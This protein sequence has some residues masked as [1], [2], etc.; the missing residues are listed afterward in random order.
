M[1]IGACE[2]ACALHVYFQDVTNLIKLQLNTILKLSYENICGV[3]RWSF[4]SKRPI[5]FFGLRRWCFSAEC[6][7]FISY[8]S[9]LSGPRHHNGIGD[10]GGQ[11]DQWGNV[12]GSAG[13]LGLYAV[14]GWRKITLEKIFEGERKQSAFLVKILKSASSRYSVKCA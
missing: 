12:D 2:H 6:P 10:C 3:W 5:H 11:S 1:H 14:F 9:N 7:V 8:P 13:P 4:V